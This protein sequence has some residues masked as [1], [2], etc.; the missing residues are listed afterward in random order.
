MQAQKSHSL[1]NSQ[2]FRGDRSRKDTS[3]CILHSLLNQGGRLGI[4]ISTTGF[5]F[6]S[7][8]QAWLQTFQNGLILRWTRNPGDGWWLI[9]Y[10]WQKLGGTLKSKWDIIIPGCKSQRGAGLSQRVGGIMQSFNYLCG[11]SSET[12]QLLRVK[13]VSAENITSSV[14]IHKLMNCNIFII[15]HCSYH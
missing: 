9:H 14:Q 15:P 13:I 10:E 2:S 4:N 7:S 6:S 3:S 1:N 11:V 8:H 12:L 5:S